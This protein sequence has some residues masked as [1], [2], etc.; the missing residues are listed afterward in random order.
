MGLET[1][2]TR[3]WRIKGKWKEERERDQEDEPNWGKSNRRR[4]KSRNKEEVAEAGRGADSGK[5]IRIM[6]NQAESGA[7]LGKSSR[8][9]K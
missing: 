4:R 6:K 5:S 7:E 3:R 9:R 2:A 1:Y 8:R